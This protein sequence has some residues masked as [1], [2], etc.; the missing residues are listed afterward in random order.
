MEKRI[1]EKVITV[2]GQ[3]YKL[4]KMDARSASY[5]AFL[6]KSLI[7]TTDDAGQVLERAQGTLSKRE[8]FSIQND[9]L[10]TCYHVMPADP[11]GDGNICVLDE[12]GNFVN[13]D[14]VTDIGAVVL[15]TIQ[16]L[17]F[18]VTDFFDEKF[19]LEFATTFRNIIPVSL[20]KSTNS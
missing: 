9:L 16:A 6:M 19:R 10:Y 4:K 17:A 3:Q 5:M 8:F 13:E 2:G 15:L 1:T 11:T 12:R 18:N 7:P 14:L 20:K